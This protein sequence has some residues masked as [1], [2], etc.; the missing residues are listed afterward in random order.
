MHHFQATPV[1]LVRWKQTGWDDQ[2][3]RFRPVRLQNAIEWAT[4]SPVNPRVAS[5]LG[6]ADCSPVA[7][8]FGGC[9]RPIIDEKTKLLYDIDHAVLL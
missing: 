7:L 3:W 9:L 8:G 5:V 2:C 4:P 1:L 6:R